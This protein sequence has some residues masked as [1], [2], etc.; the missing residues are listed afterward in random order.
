MLIMAVV[1]AVFYVLLLN[2]AAR[3]GDSPQILLT[4]GLSIGAQGLGAGIARL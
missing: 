4:I 1:G 2:R 3:F